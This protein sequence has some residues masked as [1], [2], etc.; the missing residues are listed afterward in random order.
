M[1]TIV[2]GDG[3]EAGGAAGAR[4]LAALSGGASGPLLT[5]R[6]LIVA[7]ALVAGGLLVLIVCQLTW[8]IQVFGQSDTPLYVYQARS[9]LQGRW[10][11]GL[12]PHVYNDVVVIAGKDYTIYPPLP[13]VLLL[14]FVAIWGTQTSDIFFTAACAALNLGLIYLLFE[15]ARAVGLTRRPWWQHLV[16]AVLLWVG[17]INLFLSVGG[18]LWFTAH[19]VGL[20]CALLAL[21]AALRRSFTWSAAFL[22]CG[23]FCRGTLLLAFPLVFFMALQEH[24]G[25]NLFA[26]A[27]TAV[28]ARHF[29]WRALPWRR[30]AGP[31][32]VLVVTLAL[33]MARNAAVFGSPLESGYDVIIRQR[34]PQ[35]TDGVFSP[36]YVWPNLLASFYRFPQISFAGPYDRIPRVDFING[37]FGTSVFITTP[38]FLLLFWR[39]RAFHPLRAAVWLT[40]G[41]LVAAALLFHATGWREFGARYLFEAYPFAFLLLALSDL[42]MDWRF[43]ALGLLGV[44]TSVAG[45]SQYWGR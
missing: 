10:D 19:V 26:R 29:N 4:T 45:A 33:Y 6:N 41:L 20:T 12:D 8:N 2:T 22:A 16:L 13:A 36:R 44:I 11:I 23:F 17:S 35:V 37:G 9:F 28:R 18:D 25:D 31:A 27:L 40:V 3:A 1:A 5:R 39:N 14:P 30:L 38:L 34:Y 15:Q 42:R 43:Y 24:H 21:I 7:A 32:V